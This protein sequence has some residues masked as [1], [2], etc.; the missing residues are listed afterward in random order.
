MKTFGFIFFNMIFLLQCHENQTI[1]IIFVLNLII[2]KRYLYEN[3]SNFCL[4]G[5]S[6]GTVQWKITKL[7]ILAKYIKQ[8]TKSLSIYIFNDSDGIF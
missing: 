1:L 4:E 6:A 7:N 2:K 5:K 3:Y 8:L